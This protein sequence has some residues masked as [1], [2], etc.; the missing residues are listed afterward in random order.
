MIGLGLGI[1]GAAVVVFGAVLLW[2]RRRLAV[3]TVQGVSMMPAL[4]EGERVL[5]RRTPG[6]AVRTG[7]LVVFQRARWSPA[8]G[9][10]ARWLIKRVAAAAGEPV[11]ADVR[12]AV[13]DHDDQVPSGFLVVLGDNAAHSSDS[14][15]WGYIRADQVLGVVRRS[16]GSGGQPSRCGSSVDVAGAGKL[17]GK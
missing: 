1:G 16:V 7:Q 6:A 9:A 8:H 4:R 3:V 14:R 5:V 12:A 15:Q 11:P 17:T 13:G 10:D 2:V